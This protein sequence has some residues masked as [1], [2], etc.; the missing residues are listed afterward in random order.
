MGFRSRIFI[1]IAAAALAL[2]ACGG[3][4]TSGGASAASDTTFR[5]GVGSNPDS[6]DPHKAQGT[7]ENDVIGDMFI[8]LFT[9]D[10]KAHPV[11]GVAESWVVSE[12]QKTW[13]FKL[14]KTNWSDG[15]PVTAKDFEFALRRLED[16]K[17]L[18][19]VY[20][21]L[22]YP[23]MNAQAV[24]G[25]KVPPE[26]LGVKA[27]DDYTL[28]IKLEYPAPYLPGLLKHYTAFPVPKHAVEKFGDQ[29]TRPE[30]IV[31]NGPYKLVE[32]RSGDFLHLKKNDAF[33]DAA[34]VCFTDVIFYT[35]A[36]H[37][38]MVRRAEAGEI[39]MN[40]S[41]PTGQ[42]EQTEKRLPGW[43]RVAPMMS[44]TYLSANQTKAPFNDARVR[45]AMALAVDREHITRN[46]LKGGEIP[47]YSFVPEGMNGYPKPAEFA[48]KS[49]P[50]DQRRA[51]AKALLEQAG[52]GPNKPLE[53]E[54][55]YR[56][57]GN[58]PRIA[59]VL[60]ENWGKIAEW[61]KPEIRQ[62]DA[63]DLYKAMQQKDYIL[64]DGGWV[65]D[66]NDAYNFLYLLD[67]RTGP[68]NYGGYSNPA[69]DRLID[70]SNVEL[71]PA[72][73]ADI[74][75]QA[76]QLMLDETATI[77]VLVRVTQDIVSPDIT[78]Y[79]DNPEDIHRTRYMCRK[80]GD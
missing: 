74:L 18:G 73:R 46:I 28:E 59:P 36:D 52:Y 7:W 34:N 33:D 68:M 78:G 38:A 11:P 48:W 65:A 49:M 1:G 35:Q 50:L 44:T 13:T 58:N 20:A 55:I 66:Y 30:N 54:Y 32:W 2:S 67:S 21:S 76:E 41:F 3:P 70:A 43:P 24:N 15:T 47:A 71:D 51:E 5:R 61:V 63:K 31:V 40:N 19:A 80:K 12:D 16:P 22:Q 77:P 42:L 23:I 72:K 29:W 25:G 8:G 14:R 79:E 57:S 6:V 27:L 45:K 64:S 62:V 9:D 37:D 4:S 39:D 56:A 26:D 69:Y 60:Q 17:T 75:K 10:A 53:F